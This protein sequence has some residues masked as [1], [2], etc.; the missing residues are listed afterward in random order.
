MSTR[1]LDISTVIVISRTMG[2]GVLTIPIEIPA[3]ELALAVRRR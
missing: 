3:G 2:A 1:H